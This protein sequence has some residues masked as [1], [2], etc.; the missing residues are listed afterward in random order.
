[1]FISLANLQFLLLSRMITFSKLLCWWEPKIHSLAFWIRFSRWCKWND[2]PIGSKCGWT[3]VST[4][5]MKG[6]WEFN[7]NVW[8]R[9]MYSQK[10]N[11]LTSLFPTQSYNVLS[12]NFHINVSVSDLYN[13]RINLPR[14]DCGIYKSLTDTWMWKLGNRPRS[15]IP[16]N[17]CFESSV[18]RRR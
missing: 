1:M 11:C 13:P 8:F 4:L 10:W 5:Q 2:S 9:F 7:I 12:R 14:I 18:Q 15:F 16:G 3:E 6:R 17:I